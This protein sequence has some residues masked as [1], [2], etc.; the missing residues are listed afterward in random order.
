MKFVKSVLF[1]LLTLIACNP[2]DELT[3]II[4][5]VYLDNLLEPDT[6]KVLSVSVD[7]S[8]QTD[9]SDNWI[10][11]NDMKGKMLGSQQFESGENFDIKGFI[12]S[13]PSVVCVSVLE[14][15]NASAMTVFDLQSYTGIQR[16][17]N[18]HITRLI[19]NKRKPAGP[20]R[21]TIN[22]SPVPGYNHYQVS[23]DF[24]GQYFDMNYSSGVTTIDYTLFEWV[25]KI[26]ITVSTQ[27]NEIRYLE[28]ENPSLFDDFDFNYN[29][30]G[31]LNHQAVITLVPNSLVFSAI[32]GLRDLKYNKK[33]HQKGLAL[34]E[35]NK[36]GG[37]DKIYLGYNG[38]FPFYY[39]E[40]SLNTEE[41]QYH[42]EKLG[43]SP[44]FGKISVP[45]LTVNIVD[46]GFSTFAISGAEDYD[47]LRTDWY[48]PEMPDQQEFKWKIHCAVDNYPALLELPAE[49]KSEY[50]NLEFDH[51]QLVLNSVKVIKNIDRYSYA[52]M[53]GE[54][55]K[56]NQEDY[57]AHEYEFFIIPGSQDP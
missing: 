34:A 18:W 46:D 20:I 7:T 13:R 1:S 37:S 10:F 39:T 35:V 19:E 8:W 53:I 33:I 42:Y 49:I 55:I 21:I 12:K 51:D 38:G 50:L 27:S 9:H 4:G 48:L 25:Y 54:L 52:E 15:N 23:D 32:R 30:F 43:Q 57:R 26:G 2:E 22:N 56:N 36:P 6:I 28:I 5:S 45:E 16:G 3:P 47:H 11:V 14:V 41:Y 24:G 31:Y 17:S 29:D 40:L 44:D